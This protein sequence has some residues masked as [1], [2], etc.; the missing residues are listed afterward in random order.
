MQRQVS[1]YPNNGGPFTTSLILS[2]ATANNT[3]VT[4]YVSIFTGQDK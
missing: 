2:Q 3:P 1:L 4:I